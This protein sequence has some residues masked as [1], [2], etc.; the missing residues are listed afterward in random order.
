VAEVPITFTERAAGQSKMSGGI[1]LEAVVRVVRWR[2]T[3]TMHP[4]PAPGSGRRQESGDRSAAP[5]HSES[6]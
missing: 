1:V 5:E 6:A 4:W 2:A 3:D